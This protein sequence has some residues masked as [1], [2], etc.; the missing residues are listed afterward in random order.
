LF[1]WFFDSLWRIGF[2]TL[3][4]E[5]SL[6]V[7]PSLVGVIIRF[8]GGFRIESFAS[9]PATERLFGAGISG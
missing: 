3:E 7:S 4:A 2:G 1:P 8:R 6:P 9:R 5:M